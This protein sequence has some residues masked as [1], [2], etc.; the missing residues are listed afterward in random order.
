MVYQPPRP[1]YAPGRKDFRA[2]SRREYHRVRRG[3]VAVRVNWGAL[4]D[5][6]KPGWAAPVIYDRVPLLAGNVVYSVARLQSRAVEIPP[7]GRRAQHPRAV[8]DGVVRVR[9]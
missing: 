3:G 8:V 5:Y 6:L 7:V 9:L 4:G 2:C 1:V